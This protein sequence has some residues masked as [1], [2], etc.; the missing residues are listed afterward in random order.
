MNSDFT[1]AYISHQRFPN[2]FV[3]SRQVI[4]TVSAI[5]REGVDIS[6]IYPRRWQFIGTSKDAEKHKLL[7]FYQIENGFRISP[8]LNLPYSPPGLLK[9]SN[10]LMGSLYASITKRDIIYTRNTITTLA[11]L[12]LRRNVIYEATRIY[13]ENKPDIIARLGRYTRSSDLLSIIAQSEPVRESLINAGADPDKVRVIHNGFD[14]K[15][16]SRLQSRA[17]ARKI[18][19]WNLED[20]IVCY[21]GRV[22]ID[23]GAMTIL[24]LAQK[25]P[26]I[27]YVL[28]GYS[29]YDD[30]DWIL[31]AAADR[32]LQNIMLLPWVPTR[33]LATYLFASDVLLVPPTADPMAKYRHTVL[34]MKIFSYM[35]AEGCIFAPALQGI[36]DVLNEGNAVLVEPDNLD[37][38]AATL[39]RLL[40]D[41]DRRHA[42]AKQARADSQNYTWQS[43]GKKTVEFIRDRYDS[44]HA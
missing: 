44:F 26:G 36:T 28:I 14:P 33:E 17:D 25:T 15:P 21:S 20:Q 43:R 2:R 16:F 10:G 37:L 9:L 41:E 38:S 1:I 18:L 23:K 19:G 6:L 30:D 29:E 13:G 5:A 8:L 35:A 3:G 31:N 39:R 12:G 34:P 22:D 32:D 42:I 7:D 40:D 24:D 4:H 27:K 11:A